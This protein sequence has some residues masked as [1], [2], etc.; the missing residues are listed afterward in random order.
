MRADARVRV[1]EPFQSV[2]GAEAL[3]D[4]RRQAGKA[5]SVTNNLPILSV[6]CLG[7]YYFLVNT[8][9]SL[10]ALSLRMS[11]RILAFVFISVDPILTDFT[12]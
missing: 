4:C 10:R 5:K 11:L 8:I 1:Q 9:P 2:L 6:L 3:P 7:F 12:F